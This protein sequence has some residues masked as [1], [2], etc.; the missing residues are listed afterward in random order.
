[1]LE[2]LD[3]W[4]RLLAPFAPHICEEI[5]ERMG[6]KGFISKA[7]WPTYQE[8]RVNVKAEEIEAYVKELI[9]DAYNIIKATK[10]SPK[11]IHLYVAAPWK[12][13]VYLKAIKEASSKTITM[14][15]LMTELLKEPELKNK[16]KEISRFAAKII[17]EINKMPPERKETLSQI[18][19]I[20]EIKILNEAKD[21]FEKELRAKI[22]VWNEEDEKRYDPKNK[23][24]NATPYRP[25]IYME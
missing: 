20:D 10:I 5:W 23:A 15:E 6:K 21:F 13:K 25:A 22:Y 16:A 9:E 12:W 19:E 18:G 3:I 1:M 8:E 17:D 24:P 14:K 4:T 11:Q 7:E 2:I